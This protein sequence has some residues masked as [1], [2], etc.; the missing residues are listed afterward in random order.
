MHPYIHPGFPV[1]YPA[2][3]FHGLFDFHILHLLPSVSAGE[4]NSLFQDQMPARSWP[5][6]IT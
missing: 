6:G 5:A 1:Y 2:K 3:C 4:K